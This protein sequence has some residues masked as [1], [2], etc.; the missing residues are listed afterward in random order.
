MT[1][2]LL[3]L[4]VGA[5][6]VLG[7]VAWGVFWPR[8]RLFG[9]ARS[10]LDANDASSNRVALT[11]DDG[12]CPGSTD[13]ILDTLAQHGVRATFFVIGRHCELHPEL[14]RRIADEG[15]TIG[16]HTYDHHRWGLLRMWAYWSD[17]IDRTQRAVERVTGEAPRVFRA[18]MGFRAPPLVRAARRRGL[19]LW[20]WS[21]RAYD[22]GLGSRRTVL[23]AARS[24]RP[25]DVLLLHDGREPAGTRRLGLT[26]DTLPEV[27][28]IL[29]EAGLHPVPLPTASDAHSGAGE[30][31]G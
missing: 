15:H 12:P 2:A 3:V 26:A 5:G 30:A 4:A 20:A 24:M 28:A 25:G 8:A 14:V 10:R 18:P 27:L 23:H 7:V 29:R 17:Q 11:F 19:T 13:R 6:L 9:R 21:R 22:A 16:N 31:S 1:R